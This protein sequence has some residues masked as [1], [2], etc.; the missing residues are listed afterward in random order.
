MTRPNVTAVDNAHDLVCIGGG[1]G[2]LAAAASASERGLSCLVLEAS[3]FVGGCGA[4]S[5]GLLWAPAGEAD[6]ID[7]A[8]AYLAHVQGE[9]RGDD[10]LRHQVV[11]AVIEAFAEHLRLG[12]DLEEVP[13]NPDAFHP[14]PGSR[15]SGRMWEVAFDGRRLGHLRPLLSPS[16]H[17]RIGLRHRELYGGKR[18]SA[19]AADEAERL[20]AR[21]HA[22]DLLT[23][24]PGLTA[25]YL[26][27]AA[28]TG[29][30]DLETGARVT[31]LVTGTG[32]RVTGVRLAD[33]RIVNARLAVLVATGGY[34]W[35]SDAAD[36][37]GLPDLVEAGPP[38]TRGDHLAMAGEIGAEVARG[39]GPQ[40][41]LGARVRPD[42]V[43]PGTDA[44]LHS[45]L[46][47]VLG[48]PHTLV[49]NRSGRRF[50]DESYYVGINAALGRWSADEKQWQNVPCWLIVDEQFRRRYPLATVPAGA[51]YPSTVISADD[52]CTLAA[53]L[54]VDPDA[55]V[56]TLARFNHHAAAGEDLDFGRGA[57]AFVRRRYGDPQHEPNA[58]LGPVS[59]PPFHA[60]PLR[61]L[62]TGMCS[63]GLRTDAD[64]RVQRRSGVAVPG[65][66]ATGN[67]AA[68]SEFRGYVTGYANARNV[69]MARR[70][71]AHLSD[72][73]G[74]NPRPGYPEKEGTPA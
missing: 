30:A 45:Q 64:A 37:E 32:V 41:A 70:A 73:T 44:P 10:E 11:S 68:T 28:V 52:P 47:D 56:A 21:R 60:L 53:L 36:L 31:S 23:M 71:V 59:E 62:G 4:Y 66:Y 8:N 27:A 5:G 24:G 18:D 40:F 26:H 54:G 38:T 3:D 58:N 14:A 63:L 7:D 25:A 67:S 55:L 72:N 20:L 43:H 46:F 65:L 2:G 17:Y 57:R 33:G 69:A 42:D 48:L 13:G 34:G 6:C 49:V 16:P 29:S 39:G 74:S 12:I 9:R 15:A 1:L 22:D 61:M 35:A 19:R 50:G 51:D